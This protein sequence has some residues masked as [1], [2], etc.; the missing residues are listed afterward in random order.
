MD[1]KTAESIFSLFGDLVNQGEAMVMVTHDT[2]LAKQVTRTVVV[3]DGQV[4]D[5]H[6]NRE[7]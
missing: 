2:D 4:I 6:L 1:S 7:S 3:S 5:E